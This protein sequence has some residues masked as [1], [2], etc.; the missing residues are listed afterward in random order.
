MRE[1]ANGEGF[2]VAPA[3]IDRNLADD[4]WTQIV[5]V[6]A[7]D[8]VVGA[9]LHTGSGAAEQAGA[10]RA[11]AAALQGLGILKRD[12]VGDVIAVH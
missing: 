11:V 4:V 7:V 3:W 6:G 10:R 2:V 5:A 9:G 12:A 8:C 1:A